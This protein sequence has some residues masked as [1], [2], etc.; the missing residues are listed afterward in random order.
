MRAD[1]YWAKR[2]VERE[3]EWHNKSRETIEQ[4]L[5]AQYERS[6]QRIKAEI[7]QLYGKFSADNG[8]SI[9]EARKLID[10]NEFRVW[11]KDIEEYIAEYKATGNPKILLELN[12]LSMRSRISRLDK[13]YGDTLKELDKLGQETDK[14][15]TG[16]LKD[17]Y[18]DS[19]LKNAYDLAKKGN[20]PVSVAVDS[21]KIE[22][23]LRTPW[24]GKNYSQRIWANSDKL[25]RAIQDTI[26]NGVHRGVSVNKMA[27][28]VQER[29]NVSKNDAVR[30]VRTEMNYVLNQGALDSI[31]DAKMKYFKFIATLDSRTSTTCRDH[32][33]KIYRVDEA[34]TG[35]NVP[36]LHPRCRST[37]A[38]TLGPSKPTKGS[39]LSKVDGKYQ[40]VPNNM[41]YD[42]W[43]SIYVDKTKTLDDWKRERSKDKVKRTQDS[44][45]DLQTNNQV[46]VRKPQDLI[47]VENPN[48]RVIAAR[49]YFDKDSYTEHDRMSKNIL[50]LSDEFIK[51]ILLDAFN[52]RKLKGHIEENGTIENFKASE[53]TIGKNKVDRWFTD[54]GDALYPPNEGAI[55]ESWNE[56]LAIGTKLSRYGKTSGKYLSPINTPFDNRAMPYSIEYYAKRKHVYI[57]LKP[58][59]VSTGVIAPA[60]G[61]AGGGIQ[62]KTEKP[63][64]YY[65]DEGYL[66]EVD[67]NDR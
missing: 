41:D 7:E 20:G 59:P 24:S 35:S 9:A 22:S 30:L 37:I 15:I 17:A 8:V 45:K 19:R 32:D 2:N 1:S 60:F 50:S 48:E 25:A 16:F 34:E 4:E 56:T 3:A 53:Y 49:K 38:G 29:M 40:P 43:K 42:D 12:T 46:V 64:Q 65:L 55:A 14:K 67:E 11:R 57:V 31:K 62:H 39:R 6:A 66:K 23:V 13:L 28:E 26:V 51:L 21:K 61:K 27:K 44:K 36:P 52:K 10:G 18:K 58:L 54:E 63:I 5:V 47:K 33:G